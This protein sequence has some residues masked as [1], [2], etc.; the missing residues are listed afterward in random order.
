M[1]A[2]AVAQRFGVDPQRGL[3]ATEAAERLR[4]GGPNRLAGTKKESGFRA[5][6]RQYQDFMQIIL[7]AA[8]V[9]NQL[10][11]G[12]VGTTLLLIGLTVFNAVIGLRQVMWVEEMLLP[13]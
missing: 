13:G 2:G 9:V 11:T 10:V 12:E 7:L 8:G 1:D 6:V 5:F 4:T 3:G